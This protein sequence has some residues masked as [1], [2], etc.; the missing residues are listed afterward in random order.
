MA[1]CPKCNGPM[2]ALP[3]EPGEQ[4]GSARRKQCRRHGLLALPPNSAWR[5]N[6]VTNGTLQFDTLFPDLT[7]PKTSNGNAATSC[8]N[9]IDSRAHGAIG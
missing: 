4:P 2:T 1:T 9:T 6:A 7:A 3:R 5:A 8:G